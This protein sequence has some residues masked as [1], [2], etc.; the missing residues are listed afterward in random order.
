MFLSGQELCQTERRPIGRA[1]RCC[2]RE[3]RPACLRVDC[4]CRRPHEY[5]RWRDLFCG[6]GVGRFPSATISMARPLVDHS[7]PNVEFEEG[8]SIDEVM[9]DGQALLLDFNRNTFLKIAASEY[10]DRIKYV[11]GRAKNN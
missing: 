1:P 7:I 11:S 2:H 4:N 9:P 10:G 3:T 6:N 8:K 5:A